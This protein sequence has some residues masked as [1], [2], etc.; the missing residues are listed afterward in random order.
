[1]FE[2]NFKCL[3]NLFSKI[4]LKHEEDVF[5]NR[6]NYYSFEDIS[7]AESKKICNFFNK[8]DAQPF[9]REHEIFRAWQIHQKFEPMTNPESYKDISLELLQRIK[10]S[11]IVKQLGYPSPE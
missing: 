3:K 11:E 7:F 8:N 2:D 5:E 1:M 6:K 9:D 10:N 4:G